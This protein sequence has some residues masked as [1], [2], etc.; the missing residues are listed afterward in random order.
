MYQSVAELEELG[1][2]QLKAELMRRSLKCGGSLSERANRLFIIKN[3]SPNDY[4]KELM[5]KQK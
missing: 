3:L 2:D 5:A 4:P 1:L